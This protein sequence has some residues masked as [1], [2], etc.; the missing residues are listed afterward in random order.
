MSEEIRQ[1]DEER[2]P[3]ATQPRLQLSGERAEAPAINVV[4]VAHIKGS[5]RIRRPAKKKLTFSV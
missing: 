1:L 3:V 2:S 5:A 4:V